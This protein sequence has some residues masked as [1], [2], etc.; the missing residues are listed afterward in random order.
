MSDT[1]VRIPTPLRGLTGGAGE[2]LVAAGT[3]RQAL[4]ELERRHRG[5]L[6][7]V[8]DADG[9]PRRFVN[10]FVD[11]RSLRASGGLD[12]PLPASAVISI[13]PAVAGG[14]P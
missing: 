5:L 14:R 13:V 4:D 9:N 2:V 8:L 12:A 3:V 7:K 11:D 10:I 1:T 6:E